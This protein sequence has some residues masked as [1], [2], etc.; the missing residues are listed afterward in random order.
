MNLLEVRVIGLKG[1]K[2][3]EQQPEGK[4]LNPR[5]TLLSKTGQD[6]SAPC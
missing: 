2:G 6:H 3:A 5:E 4:A 1:V